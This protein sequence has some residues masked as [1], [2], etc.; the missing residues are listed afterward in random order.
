MDVSFSGILS[1]L[2]EKVNVAELVSRRLFFEIKNPQH[3]SAWNKGPKMHFWQP[4]MLKDIS[5][6]FNVPTPASL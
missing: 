2:E 1:F 6:F 5:V 3:K 4:G